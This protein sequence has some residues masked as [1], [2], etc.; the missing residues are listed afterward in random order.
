MG[1]KVYKQSCQNCLLSPDRIVSPSR[2]KEII[3][4]CREEQVHF[5]CHKSSMDGGKICCKTFY[6][7]LGHVSQLARIAQRLGAVEFVDLPDGERLP[8]YK[9]TQKGGSK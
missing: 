4:D 5:V 1:F 6:D 7:K 2:A 3:K 9:E 8:S